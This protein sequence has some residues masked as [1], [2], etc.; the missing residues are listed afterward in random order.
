MLVEAPPYGPAREVDA[1]DEVRVDGLTLENV[2][3]RATLAEDGTLLS[4]VER[5]PAARHSPRRATSSSSTTTSPS[6]STPG[7]STRTRSTRGRPA[8]AATSH[9]VSSTPLRAEIAFERPSLRQVVRLDAGSR[10]LEFHTTVDWHESHTLLKV[11]FPL[12]VRA[13]TATYEMP[14]GYAERPTHYSTSWD[15]ARYEVP[16]HRWADLSEHGFGVALL[17]DSKYG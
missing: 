7:T 8:P 15:R 10:R 2:H 14:F 5:R 4:L 12:A 9:A 3:L 6:R 11:C 16:G 1:D 13:P 17:N